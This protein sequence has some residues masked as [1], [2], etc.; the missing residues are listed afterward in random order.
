[1]SLVHVRDVANGMVLAAEND[2]STGETYCLGSE[3]AFSTGEIAQ[4]LAEVMEVGVPLRVRVPVFVTY[5]AACVSQTLGWLLKRPSF[6][7]LQRVKEVVRSPWVCSI[8]K[9]Q[10]QLGYSPEIGLR[11]GLASTYEWYVRRGCL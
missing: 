2:N 8:A 1:M 6:L 7:N 10:E 3:R 4:T 11:D 9:A 5:G